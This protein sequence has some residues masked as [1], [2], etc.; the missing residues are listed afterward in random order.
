MLMN[1][2]KIRRKKWVTPVFRVV[3]EALRE[4]RW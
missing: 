4:A 1:V 2:L 3:R